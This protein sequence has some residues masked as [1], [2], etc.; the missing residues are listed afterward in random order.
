MA[1]NLASPQNLYEFT[2]NLLGDLGEGRITPEE[3]LIALEQYGYL[4]DVLKDSLESLAASLTDTQKFTSELQKLVTGALERI[5][6]S[7]PQLR[8]QQP[9]GP[10]P[11]A[12]IASRSG[13]L[14]RARQTIGATLSDRQNH[15]AGSRRV[16]I[17]A[18]VDNWVTQSR[19]KISTEQ[20][21][22]GATLIETSL[23][24]A[25]SQN[26]NLD[27]AMREVSQ[28]LQKSLPLAS[29]TFS[30]AVGA[31]QPL[32]KNVTR[33][34]GILSRMATA[35]TLLL[36]HTELRHPDWFATLLLEQLAST[37][38]PISQVEEAST[39]ITKT[40]ETLSSPPP[41][42]ETLRKQGGIF[43]TFAQT[44][45][46]KALAG[47]ADGV[48]LFLG[49]TTQDRILQIVLAKT[50]ERLLS[51]TD[52]LTQRL[53]SS[54]IDSPLYGQIKQKLQETI[55]S[56]RDGVSPLLKTKSLVGDLFTTVVG[57]PL[58]EQMVGSPREAIMRYLELVRV[59]ATLPAEKRIFASSLSHIPSW[60][61]VWFLG[62]FLTAGA[63]AS[64]AAP[65]QGF[66]VSQ[67]R[68]ATAAG[69]FGF[70]LGAL[71]GLGAVASA[72]LAWLSGGPSGGILGFFGRGIEGILGTSLPGRWVYAARRRASIPTRLVDDMPLLLSLVVVVT[73]V[74]LF[75]LPTFLNPSFISN[76]SK[77][78]ALLCS[79]F[80]T[81]AYCG[82]RGGPTDQYPPG[83]YF[84][85]GSLNLGPFDCF[86]PTSIGVSTGDGVSTPLS[87][88]EADLVKAAIESQSSLALYSCVLGCSTNPINI[89]S[90]KFPNANDE[91]Y[92]SVYSKDH[93][94]NIVWWSNA[95]SHGPEALAENMA[96]EM[97][98][99]LQQRRKDIFEAWA[100]GTTTTPK[101]YC[102]P[103]GTYASGRIETIDETFAETARF[104]LS[105]NGIL[106]AK[107]LQSV[108]FFD[109]LFLQCR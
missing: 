40:A 1:E 59:N 98:H 8:R 88:K 78:S 99:I 42:G 5:N 48:F 35:P 4:R 67:E 108:A 30:G 107:C 46:Q 95:F 73:V 62:T 86:A 82:G 55:A 89:S 41:S 57:S 20:A 15:L 60:Q 19:G 53:G 58:G 31:A 97:A 56:P 37:D 29:S 24:Q 26:T 10:L 70:L 87:Q 96:H 14:A 83:N 22:A 80:T 106:N 92:G 39:K 74:V 43:S 7:L 51:D 85:I 17:K 75:V 54:F 11:P 90:Y 38:T 109:S 100:Y 6:E 61:H 21:Q 45:L 104:Y 72:P 23:G 2:G 28:N 49:P 84:D 34:E 91:V 16:F 79:E 71:A 9:D 44:G 103:L 25:F 69:F 66:A 105:N 50:T 47:V 94:G 64:F 65:T 52:T 13:S 101:A 81:G 3:A 12:E 102:G 33:D 68:G 36:R 76:L 77:S 93:P 18:L 27:E 63:D 32:T